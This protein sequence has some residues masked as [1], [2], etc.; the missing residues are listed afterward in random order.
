LVAKGSGRTDRTGLSGIRLRPDAQRH[1]IGRTFA[2]SLAAR[3][4]EARIAL[5]LS[6]EKGEPASRKLYDRL[7]SLKVGET[8]RN[9]C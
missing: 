8:K 7:G 2:D 4:P 3:M 5:D 6:V 9:P 1:G